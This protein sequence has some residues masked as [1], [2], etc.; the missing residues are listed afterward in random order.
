[1]YKPKQSFRSKPQI[2]FGISLDTPL[3]FRNE[4]SMISPSSLGSTLMEAEKGAQGASSSQHRY[5]PTHRIQKI[6]PNQ[7]EVLRL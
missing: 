3:T 1:M 4:H 2:A 7:V 5:C 6:D